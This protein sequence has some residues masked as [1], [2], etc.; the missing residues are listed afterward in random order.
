MDHGCDLGVDVFEL[1][2]TAKLLRSVAEV[3]RSS[4]KALEWPDW[5]SGIPDHPIPESWTSVQIDAADFLAR[6]MANL[7]ETA[8]SLDEAANDYL[9]RDDEARVTFDQMVTE[10]GK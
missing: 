9:A 6:T 7:E 8:D 2:K 1:Y 10:D 3:Y 5:A 4:F